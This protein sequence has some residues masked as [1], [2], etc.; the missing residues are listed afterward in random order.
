MTITNA[1]RK[2]EKITGSKSTQKGHFYCFQYKGY[3][4]S[5]AKNGGQEYATNYY[6]RKNGF[7]DD[8]MTDYFAGTF[9]D[10]LT[11]AFKFVDSISKA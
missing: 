8:L 3:E 1:I 2:A 10:N 7:N 9:H 11:Q 4:V 6:T 5:F